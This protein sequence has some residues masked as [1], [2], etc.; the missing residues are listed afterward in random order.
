MLN[1]CNKNTRN[2][3]PFKNLLTCM[4]V[5]I[6]GRESTIS[7]CIK[8]KIMFKLRK[9]LLSYSDIPVHCILS[10][11]SILRLILTENTVPSS[12]YEFNWG[13]HFSISTENDRLNMYN[14][15]CVSGILLK[16]FSAGTLKMKVSFFQCSRGNFLC[17]FPHINIITYNCAVVPSTPAG[18][19]LF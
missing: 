16:D 13:G 14:L 3:V 4:T 11:I 12:L 8:S 15:L 5:K 19:T 2:V 9:I 6:T 7:S 10:Q 17:E 1:N 18:M